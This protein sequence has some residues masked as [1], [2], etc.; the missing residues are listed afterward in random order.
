MKKYFIKRIG[1][2]LLTWLV[3]FMAIFIL[4]RVLPGSAFVDTH[5]TLDQIAAKKE[6]LGLNDPVFVQMFRY[7]KGLLHGD[8]GSGTF[9][10]NGVP[11]KT[12]LKECLSNSLRIGG[13]AVLIGVTAGMLLGILSAVYKGRAIDHI[14]TA[15][16]ILGICLPSYVFLIYLQQLFVYKL[17]LLPV[18]FDNSRWLQSAIL[19][20]LSMSLFSISTIM[21]FTRK[22]IL[23]VLDSDFIKL[24][25][26]KGITGPKLIFGHVLRNA[27]VPI[28]TI[29]APL[30]VDL[31][32]GA[33]VIE[34]IYGI[35]GIGRLMIDAISG[36]GVDYNYVL[37][38]GMI[39]TTMYIA[40]MLV[41]DLVYGLIDP[42]IR[43]AG[44]E[45]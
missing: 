8:L 43:L 4:V 12:V 10:Y 5:M 33:T 42:R 9:L 21:R 15:L 1:M 29:I 40:V 2:S 28:V 22:Q 39:Y 14:C 16:S 27:L 7:L 45:G 36:T 30:A 32:T 37:I 31:L 41:L 44:K 3:I 13:L 25:K 19:P 6:S 23:E 35:N 18:F 34:K 26:A 17:D 20:A 38:L 11:I 24:V